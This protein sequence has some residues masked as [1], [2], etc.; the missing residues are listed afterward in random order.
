MIKSLN[1]NWR[2]FYLCTIIFRF[3]LALSDSYIHPDEHFQSFEVLT[4]KVLGYSTN[5]PWEFHSTYPARS[6]GP[7]YLVY[8]PLLYIVKTL[9]LQLTPI[10]IWY[11]ARLQITI[12]TWVITDSCLY[13]MLP[14]KQE[15]IKA[16]FFTSTS[17]I[18]LVYQSHLFSNSIETVLVLL[19]ILII[20]DLRY[21]YESKESEIQ[22]L[23]KSRSVLWLGVVISIGIFNRV[24]FPVFLIFPSWYLLKYLISR[25]ASA[26]FLIL[27]FII[28]TTSFILI[29]SISFG[30]T[31]FHQ[32]V[33]SPFEISNYVI[34]P[35]NNL[36]YNTQYE[37]LAQHGIHPYYTHLLINLPQ[38]LGPGLIY[39][40]SKAY[41]KTTPFL[42]LISGI[43]FLSIVPHQE[44]RFLIPI[45]PLS[46][47][48]FDLTSRVVRP[49]MMNV[50]YLFNAFMA[51]LLGVFHQG[52]IIPALSYLG[53]QE[54]SIQ[55]WWRTYSPPSW[56]LGS[57]SIETIS[58]KD[59]V[60]LEKSI[61][62]IDAM[63]G[64]IQDI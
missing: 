6:L 29:D 52:G 22:Q 12:L 17:Y 49:W 24:T 11:L 44:L 19:A 2:T 61:T 37:N 63:G 56:L 39:L 20:D 40:I 41:L 54:D 26:I 45:L 25:P 3:V 15:R 42:S 14:T 9:G 16:I 36:L 10:Q 1:I 30:K 23:N 51:I 64:D 5:I 53:Q 35:V 27:G 7:L 34:T 8:G 57:N 32:I 31:T 47:C 21:I 50:W 4:N 59:T 58:L 33:N 38:I 28:P 13:W 60:N 18:T 46:C 62:I 43:F 48:C 55:I